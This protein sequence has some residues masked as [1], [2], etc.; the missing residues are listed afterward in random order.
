[1]SFHPVEG[2]VLLG[3]QRVAEA[4]VVFHPTEGQLPGGQ[5]PQAYTDERGRFSL[6]T[7]LPGDGAPEGEYAV[8]VELRAPVQVG[9]EVI[10]DGRNLLPPVYSRPETTRLRCRVR[11]GQNILPP[12]V[13]TRSE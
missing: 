10:R 3:N 12:F 2:Q 11:P 5:R 8:T 6:M 1:V 9:E 13:L 7:A 4:K